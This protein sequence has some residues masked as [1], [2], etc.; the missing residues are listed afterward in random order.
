M[1]GVSD[2]GPPVRVATLIR[3]R[4]FLP[5]HDAHYAGPVD[6]EWQDRQFSRFEISCQESWQQ[7]PGHWRGLWRG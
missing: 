4:P 3:H 7:V 6:R 5:G 2:I 1:W